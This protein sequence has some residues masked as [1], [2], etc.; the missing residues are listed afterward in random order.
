[1]T[2]GITFAI[3]LIR[4]VLYSHL[5]PGSLLEEEHCS[6]D[7]NHP[8]YKVL[9]SIGQQNGPVT[10]QGMKTPTRQYH[11]VMLV[12]VDIAVHLPLQY[13]F[14]KLFAFFITMMS[15]LK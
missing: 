13:F 9:S 14:L 15:M 8:E 10:S 3:N 1:M 6:S 2:S 12:Y 11:V 7:F 5:C 4:S